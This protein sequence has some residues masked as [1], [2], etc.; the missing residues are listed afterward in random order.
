MVVAGGIY[1]SCKCDKVY[2]W[3]AKTIKMK[4]FYEHIFL[5]HFQQYFNDAYE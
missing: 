4:Q 5:S 3:C 1:V 2:C